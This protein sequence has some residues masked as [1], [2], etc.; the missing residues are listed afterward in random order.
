MSVSLSSR[1]TSVYDVEMGKARLRLAGGLQPAW[2]QSP[3]TVPKCWVLQRLEEALLAEVKLLASSSHVKASIVFKLEKYRF[4]CLDPPPPSH[5]IPVVRPKT[6][7]WWV[8]GWDER[9]IHYKMKGFTLLPPA[10][11]CTNSALLSLYYE[12]V[13]YPCPT[14]PIAKTSTIY[15]EKSG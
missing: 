1:S 13:S 5:F 12:G 6:F 11:I 2:G 10:K 8:V 7:C 15:G 9:K 4:F 3:D 14:Y